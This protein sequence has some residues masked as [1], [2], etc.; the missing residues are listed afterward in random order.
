MARRKTKN[1]SRDFPYEQHSTKPSK[2]PGDAINDRNNNMNMETPGKTDPDLPEIER[3]NN[4]GIGDAAVN[5][6][7]MTRYSSNHSKDA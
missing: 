6:E 3:A 5:D 1:T 4:E 7:K 2:Q